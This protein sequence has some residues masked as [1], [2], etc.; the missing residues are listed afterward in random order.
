[1]SSSE[2]F[3]I[4]LIEATELPANAALTLQ[5][6][7]GRFTTSPSLDPSQFTHLYRISGNGGY[8]TYAGEH[9]K[10][11]GKGDVESVTYLVDVDAEGHQVGVGELRYATPDSRNKEFAPEPFVGWMATETAHQS[12]GLGRQRLL[13]MNAISLTLYDKPLRSG[14]LVPGGAKA[15]WERLVADGLATVDTDY[16]NGDTRY[17]F[18]E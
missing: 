9:T 7:S 17:R 13:A 15:L 14:G 11:Y 16:K 5:Q 3:D 1:M 8:V 2:T 18:V 6:R 12:Q 10:D 4:K